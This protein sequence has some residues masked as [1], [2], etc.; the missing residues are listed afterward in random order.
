[1]DGFDHTKIYS[2]LGNLQTQTI[3]EQLSAG[4]GFAYF[5]GHGNPKNWATHDNGDY[6][7]WTEGFTNRDMLKLNHPDM[8]PILMVGG[9][10]NSQ[11]DVTP[12]NIIKGLLEEGLAYFSSDPEDFGSYW[13]SNWVP[14]CWSWVFVKK[15]NGGAIASMGST[16]YG[17]VNIG[18]SDSNGIPDCVEGLDGW[19]ETQFFRLYNEEH[20]DVL[21]ATY[22]QTITDYVQTFPV[23][24]DRYDCKIVETH[25][26]LGDPSLRIGGIE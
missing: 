25:V 11:F 26:L 7:N 8:Y 19:F 17:G 3:H 1:M 6:T 20:I 14:E 23:F 13:T 2:S 10:H 22:S 4:C 9:C 16:G 15:R 21:G 24:S 5:V 18:D 12:L